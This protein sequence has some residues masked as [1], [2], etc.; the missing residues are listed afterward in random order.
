MEADISG[1]LAR[2]GPGVYSVVVWGLLG[3]EQ[4]IL[5]EYSVF[6]EVE[7]PMTYET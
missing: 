3:G 6:H 7:P 4:A 5:A 1:V 2:H